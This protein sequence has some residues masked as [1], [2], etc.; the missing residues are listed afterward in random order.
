MTI[1]DAYVLAEDLITYGHD[2]MKPAFKFVH[3]VFDVDGGEYNI[4]KA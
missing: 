1:G 4:D 2:N 3:K